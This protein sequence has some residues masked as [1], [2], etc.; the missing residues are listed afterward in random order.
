MRNLKS[1]SLLSLANSYMVDSPQPSSLS[2]M[3]N[4]GSLL[5][6]CLGLQIVT[7]IFLAM[8]YTPNVDLAFTSVEHIMRDVNLGWAIR[9]AHA[10]VASFFFIF[11]YAH[12]GRG[13]YYGS[14]RSPRVLP[15]SIGVIILVVM[16]ATG[17][18]GYS[19]SPKWLYF[20]YDTNSNDYSNDLAISF[21][22]IGLFKSFY[23]ERKLK[24]FFRK[25]NIK[26]VMYFTNCLYN[27]NNI[28]QAL[29]NY[30]GIY[31]IVNL[32]NNK[33]YVGRSLTLYSRMEEHLFRFRGSKEIAKD[34]IN[35][36]LD[37]FAFVILEIYPFTKIDQESLMDKLIDREKYYIHT[38]KPTYN[39]TKPK[40]QFINTLNIKRFK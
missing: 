37:K 25:H 13:L 21:F 39:V 26:P 29:I 9:Y 28:E 4:F 18:L 27:K 34:I 7:G 8:H 5:A 12:I 6:L 10:N 15:W 16:I 11:V 38:L 36:D 33:F 2:Y 35:I 3:W 17:F 30:S 14:Y 32:E 20:I 19:Y 22:G 31:L 1:N 40:Y 24:L 23:I